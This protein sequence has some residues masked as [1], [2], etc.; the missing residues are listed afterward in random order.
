MSEVSKTSCPVICED[1]PSAT[2]LRASESGPTPC[3]VQGGPTIALY[4]P[5][6]A[7]ANLSA[8]QAKEAGLL[9]S[10]TYGPRSITSSA[11]VRLE[12]SLVNRLVAK[13]AL[14][15]SQLFRLT[16]KQRDTPLGVSISALRASVRRISDKD[17]TSWP[18]PSVHN[19]EQADQEALAK[20]RQECKERTGN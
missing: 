2:S 20:R 11:S 15:G 14:L 17:C 7:R 10:G 12:T 18:T 3:A 5:E 6:A 9:T 4:G 13:T 19:Y 8:R 1:L 16:W